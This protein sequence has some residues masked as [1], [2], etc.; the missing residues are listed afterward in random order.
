M[1][2]AGYMSSTGN[3]N[4]AIENAN[5]PVNER[6]ESENLRLGMVAAI[7]RANAWLDATR[8][9]MAAIMA[10]TLPFIGKPQNP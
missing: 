9:S 6:I 5:I 10:L 4:A 7:N 8:S 2:T 3:E 1:P